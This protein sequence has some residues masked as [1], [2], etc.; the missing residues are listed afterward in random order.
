MA[1]ATELSGGLD[2]YTR[3]MTRKMKMSTIAPMVAT[4]MAPSRPPP[5][6]TPREVNRKPPINAPNTPTTMSPITP[7][8]PPFTSCPASHPA[9]N[10]IKINQ[11]NSMISSSHERLDYVFSPSLLPSDLNDTD[12]EADHRRPEREE[13][14]QPRTDGIRVGI[15][16][17]AQ[18]SEKND[19]DERPRADHQ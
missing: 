10:P 8:P 1:L 16:P 3:L 13:E 12:G 14:Q 6:D 4:I 15:R 7:K 9:T 17:Y 19:A 18:L 5:K 2:P 11:T